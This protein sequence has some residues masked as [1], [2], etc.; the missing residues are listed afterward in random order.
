MEVYFELLWVRILAWTFSQR[1]LPIEPVFV[2]EK[3]TKD[4]SRRHKALNST[5]AVTKV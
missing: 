4:P 5:A 1:N 2:S 3:L